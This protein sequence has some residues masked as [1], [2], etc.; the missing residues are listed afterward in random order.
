MF[1]E[2]EG[3]KVPSL[4]TA[5]ALSLLLIG[6]GLCI[7]SFSAFLEWYLSIAHMELGQQWEPFIRSEFLALVVLTALWLERILMLGFKYARKGG[8][9]SY[10][11]LSR[12]RKLMACLISGM[13]ATA[14]T[15]WAMVVAFEFSPLA[16]I[17][18]GFVL[19]GVPMFWLE[20]RIVFAA[21]VEADH[22]FRPHHA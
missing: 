20:W 10:R 6:V 14:A 15:T 8:F 17:A 21:G 1:S 11:A 18:S 3:G 7:Y 9:S 13:L 5:L 12:G 22:R 4:V 2:I 16:A 19:F